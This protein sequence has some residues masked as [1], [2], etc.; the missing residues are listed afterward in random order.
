MMWQLARGL[1]AAGLVLGLA[2]AARADIMYNGYGIP[3]TTGAPG[4]LTGQVNAPTTAGVGT[5]VSLTVSLAELGY[6][7][8][9][10]GQTVADHS[11]ANCALS[12]QQLNYVSASSLTSLSGIFTVPGAATILSSDLSFSLIAGLWQAGI[13]DQAAH[14][15][16]LSFAAAGTYSAVLTGIATESET[17]F[18]QSWGTIQ[19]PVI[20]ACDT[21][22]FVCVSIED[23]PF[24]TGPTSG[25]ATYNLTGG[26]QADISVPEPASALLFGAGLVA[27]LGRKKKA[28][29]RKEGLLF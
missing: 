4:T 8:S 18:E 3:Y 2:G 21:P 14:T 23:V 29:G 24:D 1:G 15:V 27:L 17:W 6:G 5:I 26:A 7:G 20:T 9:N 22:P 11:C 12:Y 16:T 10:A 25:T 19:Q 28:S 13:S